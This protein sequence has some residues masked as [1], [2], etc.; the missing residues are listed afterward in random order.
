MT[1]EKALKKLEEIVDKME[2]GEL[3]L[4][5]SMKLYEEGVKLSEF[6]A[7][8]LDKAQLKVNNLSDIKN[9]LNVDE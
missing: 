4:D 9:G 6:C 8:C 1:Y 5:E 2:N 3:S 7:K